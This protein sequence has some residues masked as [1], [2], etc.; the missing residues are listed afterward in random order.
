[1]EHRIINKSFIPFR[2]T[3]IICTLFFLYG[4][5]GMLHA[6]DLEDIL[7]QRLNQQDITDYT[8]GT[9]KGT[10]I[11]NG[12]SCEITERGDL[13]FLVS[14][15]FGTL[16]SGFNNFFGLDDATTRIGFEYGLYD[17]LAVGIG[18]STFEKTFDGFLKYKLL[19]QSTGKIS[20]P[21]T[22]TLFTSGNLKTLESADPMKEYSFSNRMAYSYQL[23]IAR[24]FSPK[25]SLQLSPTY[26]HKNL[27]TSRID[28]NDVMAVGAGGRYKITQRFSVNME[29]YYLLPGQ[30]ADDNNNSLSFGLDI[31]TGGHIFQLLL[32]NSRAIFERSF[33]TETSGNWMEGDIHFGFNITRVFHVGGF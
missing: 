14:H 33:I 21:V 13:M 2:G 20:M 32:T 19:R 9:F 26:I 29:Y 4:T 23:L 1:M 31:E 27:V 15:R 18:R 7:N 30:S 16:N 5:G 22:L 8:E 25:L 12:H 24:K 6:Q 11:V 10:R 17:R 28:Q 3:L